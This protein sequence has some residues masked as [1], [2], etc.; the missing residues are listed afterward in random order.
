[1]N[2]D[3][4][5]AA[6]MSRGSKLGMWMAVL[7]AAKASGVGDE[8]LAELAAIHAACRSD[9]EAAEATLREAVTGGMPVAASVE[10]YVKA[11][12]LGD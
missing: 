10:A 11:H 7:M 3:K 4:L 8:V 1:M 5:L 9:Y 2:E 12:A 6:M